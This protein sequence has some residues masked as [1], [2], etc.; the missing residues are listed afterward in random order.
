MDIAV[1]LAAITFN[2]GLEGLEPL[3]VQLI[4]S[5]P[6][7]FTA[8]YITSSDNKRLKK[9]GQKADCI[10]QRRR[11]SLRSMELVT[12]ERHIAEEGITYES[13]A[14]QLLMFFLPSFF[15][16]PSHLFLFGQTTIFLDL[17]FLIHLRWP[18]LGYQTI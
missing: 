12:E 8:H 4:G 2:H 15:S 9:A 6:S 11:K 13:G 10:S 7:A 18:K 17:F 3:F 14:F 1:N 5:F 16:K